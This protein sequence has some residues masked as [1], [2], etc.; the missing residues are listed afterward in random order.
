MT[1]SR[2]KTIIAEPYATYKRKLN[3]R[4]V[5]ELV[6]DIMIFG[7]ILGVFIWAGI[8]LSS[9]DKVG[10]IFFF[11]P[12][13]P[14]IIFIIF[15]L[16]L[17]IGKLIH[18][19][20][21]WNFLYFYKEELLFLSSNKTVKEHVSLNEINYI[22][23]NIIPYTFNL[24]RISLDIFLISGKKKY[25]WE[26]GTVKS[27]IALIQGQKLINSW[28]IDLKIKLNHPDPFIGDKN[29]QDHFIYKRGSEGEG[30]EDDGVLNLIIFGVFFNY[31]FCGLIFVILFI[32]DLIKEEVQ[33]IGSLVV[34]VIFL[35]VLGHYIRNWKQS[36]VRWEYLYFDANEFKLLTEG[37]DPYYTCDIAQIEY[38]SLKKVKFYRR[39]SR[40]GYSEW[41]DIKI[42]CKSIRKK[43]FGTLEASKKSGTMDE[44]IRKIRE[45]ANCW[46][47]EIRT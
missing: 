40:G 5:S 10:L 8:Q 29:Q 20:A 42:K 22:V 24:Y 2:S 6:F 25:I 34:L 41:L 43:K 36:L 28:C 15:V 39:A 18:Y 37:K 27:E 33:N 32:P 7:I 4:L 9:I 35:T 1:K 26:F 30:T 44:L 3:L 21:Q 13:L 17:L 23:F 47:I 31:T 19:I 38:I 45:R 11:G 12:M 14:A 46:E 16:G